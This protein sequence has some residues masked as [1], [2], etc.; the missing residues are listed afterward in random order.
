MDTRSVSAAGPD[1]LVMR[2]LPAHRGEE[3]SARVLEGSNSVVWD[4]A[5]NR[6]HAKI[7]SVEFLLAR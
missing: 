7:A 5:Q 2:C 3:I 1:V 6:L 4:E